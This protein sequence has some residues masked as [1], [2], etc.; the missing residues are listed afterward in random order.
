MHFPTTGENKSKYI[1]ITVL[2]S[3]QDKI[4]CV[5]TDFSGLGCVREVTEKMEI[6]S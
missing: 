1:H 2:M 6:L 5:T 4:R 3:G